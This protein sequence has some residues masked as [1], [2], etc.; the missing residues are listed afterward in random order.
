[1]L[2][3][4]VVGVE[5]DAKDPAGSAGL[6]RCQEAFHDFRI[7]GEVLS[8]ELGEPRDRVPQL[9]LPLQPVLDN[10]VAR[11]RGAESREGRHHPVE[12]EADLA[13]VEDRLS[14]A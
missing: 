7:G 13:R 6:E 3:I 9:P 2:R 10:G 8:G 12:D 14:R 1:M 5:D 4:L 11:L